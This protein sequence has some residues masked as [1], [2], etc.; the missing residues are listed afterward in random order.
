MVQVNYQLV[1]IIHSQVDREALG[2]SFQ[3]VSIVN[4]FSTLRVSICSLQH[5]AL[6]VKVDKTNVTVA[7]S[8]PKCAG[9]PPE[10][11]K[12]LYNDPRL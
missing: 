3:Y 12:P 1:S 9:E 8:L 6:S 7:F 11:Y 4:H 5:R 10:T 2:A